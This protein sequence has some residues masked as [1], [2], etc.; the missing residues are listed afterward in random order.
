MPPAELL[1]ASNVLRFKLA[2]L[3][4]KACIFKNESLK[5]GAIKSLERSPNQNYYL[6]ILLF[7]ENISNFAVQSIAFQVNHTDGKALNRI[8]YLGKIGICDSSVIAQRAEAS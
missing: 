8:E 5:I 6:K 2:C 1:H 3:S 4:H 7:L